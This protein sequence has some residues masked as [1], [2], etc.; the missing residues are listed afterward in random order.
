MVDYSDEDTHYAA[1]TFGVGLLIGA[2]VGA[3][4]AL[5]LAPASGAHT[6][7]KLRREA[8]RLYRKSEGALSDLAEDAS[9]SAHRLARRGFKRSQRL[10]E[11]ARER[12][13]R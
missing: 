12:V 2:V 7:K 8:K 3:T 9:E 13:G 1:K 5:L 11:L 10:A 4:A 6:R